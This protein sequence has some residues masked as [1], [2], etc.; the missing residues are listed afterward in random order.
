MHKSKALSI[1]RLQPRQERTSTW[2]LKAWPI[3]FSKKLIAERLILRKRY[4]F[5]PSR[6]MVLKLAQS[7]LRRRQ[8]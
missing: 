8:M 5:S 2:S 3:K 7:A 1:L 6:S 4:I